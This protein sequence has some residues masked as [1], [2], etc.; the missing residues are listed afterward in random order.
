MAEKYCGNLYRFNIKQIEW[1]ESG[2]RYKWGI[3]TNRGPDFFRPSPEPYVLKM[4]M[5]T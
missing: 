5:D 4:I 3:I 2:E 1:G